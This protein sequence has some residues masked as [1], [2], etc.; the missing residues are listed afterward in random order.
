MIN[1]QLGKIYKIVCNNTGKTYI[2]STCEPS[3]ARRLSNHKRKF[4]SY[5]N[6]NKSSYITSVEILEG[7][8][9]EIILIEHF[10]CGSKDDLHARERYFIENTDCVNKNIPTRTKKECTN[11]T[12]EKKKEYDKVNRANNKEKIK[13]SKKFAYKKNKEAILADRKKYREENKDKIKKYRDEYR[14]RLKEQ[15]KKNIE[16]L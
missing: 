9:Y 3:L 16:G 2:G 1:Y 4:N 5:I 8:N 15:P 7:N 10:S 11:D 14:D 12:K 13:E 6:G